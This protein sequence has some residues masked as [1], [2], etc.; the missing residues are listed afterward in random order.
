MDD[1]FQFYNNNLMNFIGLVAYI[2]MN[3]NDSFNYLN[4]VMKNIN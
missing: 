1:H 2:I 4:S 3:N